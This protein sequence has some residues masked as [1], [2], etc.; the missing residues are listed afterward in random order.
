MVASGF[1]V[2]ITIFTISTVMLIVTL[3]IVVSVPAVGAIVTLFIGAAPIVPTM[4][5]VPISIL[6][7]EGNVAETQIDRDARHAGR[8][9][10]GQAD[11]GQ[12]DC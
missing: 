3:P 2:T 1:V 10:C 4:I 11:T 7:A 9:C 6:I 8:A 5:V 12:T